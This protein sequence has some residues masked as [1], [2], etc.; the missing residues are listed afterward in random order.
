MQ[1]L[2]VCRDWSL[3]GFLLLVAITDLLSAACKWQ[4]VACGKDIF[5]FLE[6]RLNPRSLRIVTKSLIVAGCLLHKRRLRHTVDMLF[7]GC[8]V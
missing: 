5:V 4:V 7:P 6:K 1:K 3:T 8:T 2:F